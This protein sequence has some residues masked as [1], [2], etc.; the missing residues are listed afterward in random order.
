MRHPAKSMI[1]GFALLGLATL[2][3][4]FVCWSQTLYSEIICPRHS[5]P[6]QGCDE[7]VLA[8]SESGVHYG[9]GELKEGR[10]RPRPTDVPPPPEHP[11]PSALPWPS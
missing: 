1:A 6:G 3:Q 5:Q 11:R 2:R 10:P 4:T 8:R 7:Q 9:A